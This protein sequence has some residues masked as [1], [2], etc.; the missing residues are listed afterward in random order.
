MTAAGATIPLAASVQFAHAAVQVLAE[1]AGVDA[2]HIK[3]PA[4]HESLLGRRRVTDPDTAEVVDEPEPRHSIDAD[5]LVRPDHVARLIKAMLA[6]GW[7]LQVPFESGSSFEHAATLSHVYLGHLDLHRSFP[8][9]GLAAAP[10]FE[11]LWRDRGSTEI[12]G[13]ACPVPAVDAQRLLLILHAVRGGR[14]VGVDVER[15]WTAADPAA[16]EAVQAL[17]RDLRAEVALAAGTGR[18]AEYAGTREYALWR[19]LSAGEASPAQMWL[20]RVRAAP[21][22][23][24]AVRIGVKLALPRVGRLAV[25]LGRTPTLGEVS[26]L[27]VRHLAAVGRALGRSVRGWWTSRGRA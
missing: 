19:S 26:R 2:L 11:R 1:D 10:A 9:I 22:L 5:V 6:H 8:G 12:A 15:S 17:A 23:P 16:R 14:A 7:T 25:E 4:V 13:V 18:L 27:W 3:G 21:D 24:S 20:A